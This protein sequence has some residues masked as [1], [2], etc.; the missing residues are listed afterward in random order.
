MALCSA[1]EGGRGG[2]ATRTREEVE[3]GVCTRK[4]MRVGRVKGLHCIIN[5][6]LYLHGTMVC[7]MTCTSTGSDIDTRS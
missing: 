1:L 7:N 6:T 3:E 5:I 4:D 2:G